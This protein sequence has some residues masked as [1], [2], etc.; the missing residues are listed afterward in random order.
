MGGLKFSMGKTRGRSSV[1]GRDGW[2]GRPGCVLKG[3]LGWNRGL[4][5]QRKGGGRL[6]M[7]H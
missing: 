2:H 7:C 6:M 1:N 3:G 4:S 5:G